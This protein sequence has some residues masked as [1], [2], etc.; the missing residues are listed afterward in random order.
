MLAVRRSEQ[1]NLDT[2]SR[3]RRL[4]V[5]KSAGGNTSCVMPEDTT[6]GW[7]RP[8]LQYWLKFPAPSPAHTNTYACTST[9]HT[10]QDDLLLHCGSSGSGIGLQHLQAQQQVGK[11]RKR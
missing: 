2:E 4:H 10:W 9:T 7:S 5:T 8:L 11:Q 6:A 3:L 1:S